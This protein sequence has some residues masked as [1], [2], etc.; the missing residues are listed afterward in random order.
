MNGAHRLF[1]AAKGTR[2]GDRP[3]NQ[4]RSLF[5]ASPETL[6][7][8][9]A[10]GLGGHPRGEVAAQLLVDVS[11]AMFRQQSKPLPDP[12]T[13][14]LQCVGKAHSAIMRFGR[15]QNPRIAPRTTAVLA[16]IQ[17]GIA[18]WAHVGDSRLYLIRDG[19]VFS[20]TSDHTQIRY[21]RQSE[22]EA[23]RPRASLT[24]CLGGLP[25]PP[26]TTCGPPT[27]LQPGDTLLLCSDGLW[28]QVPRQTLLATLSD[29]T[30]PLHEA[31]AALIEQ[32]TRAEN[33]D[34]VTAIALR[35]L[36]EPVSG[37]ID[38]GL[39]EPPVDPQLEH[40][41]AHLNQ[42]IGRVDDSN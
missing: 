42:V 24:R 33:S 36:A 15:R 2:I 6:L 19:A 32:A 40:A 30:S 22:T 28:G 9:L 3:D 27:P 4:D 38:A 17:Q 18:Y 8:G 20:Q 35:W 41:I 12:E 34:N 5:L 37:G 31:L 25:Q 23:S 39:V 26:T 14:M 29:A 7:V 11:E 1:D 10:D 13:F 21:V 16:V